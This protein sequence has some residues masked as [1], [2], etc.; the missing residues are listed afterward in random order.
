[1]STL[2]REAAGRQNEPTDMCT[3]VDT[4]SKM[5][6][7]R[8]KMHNDLEYAIICYMKCEDLICYR[9]LFSNCIKDEN[10]IENNELF[11]KG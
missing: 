6:S 7:G 10:E 11:G 8:S 3:N 2:A 5:L 1:M 9:R 4:S